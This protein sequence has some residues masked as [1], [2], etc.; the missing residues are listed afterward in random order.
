MI[1]SNILSNFSLE[2]QDV[3]RTMWTVI[4]GLGLFIGSEFKSE[5]TEI[6]HSVNIL[7]TNV[8]VLAEQAG[9]NK[10]DNIK[11]ERRVNMIEGVLNSRTKDRWT[12]QDHIE[13]A[14]DIKRRLEKLE[15]SR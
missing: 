1:R 14:K 10:A 2:K 11:L 8:A 3:F 15:D 6:K 7:N 9:T 5:M 12:K 13:F 4:A